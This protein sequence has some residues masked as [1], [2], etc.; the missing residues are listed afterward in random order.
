MWSDIVAIK[1]DETPS[2][3]TVLVCLGERK[4]SVSNKSEEWAGEFNKRILFTDPKPSN[5]SFF[6]PQLAR[7]L[8]TVNSAVRRTS[9]FSQAMHSL[10]S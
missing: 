6:V 1:M 3:K 2:T 10:R 5:V 4:R 9:Q 7:I 8:F